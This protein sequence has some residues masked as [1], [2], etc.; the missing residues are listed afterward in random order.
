MRKWQHA[1]VKKKKQQNKHH[2]YSALKV[3]LLGA[4]VIS[5]ASSHRTN[6][7]PSQRCVRK[8]TE[9]ISDDAVGPVAHPPIQYH[10]RQSR[11]PL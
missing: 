5:F 6:S 8:V 1:G 9:A 2:N 4:F 7:I 11:V 10:S 3:K